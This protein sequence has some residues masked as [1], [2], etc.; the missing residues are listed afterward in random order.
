MSEEQSA[1]LITPQIAYLAVREALIA[2]AGEQA[3]VF[4]AVIAHGTDPGN[5]FTIKS[6][7]APG[8][9][10]VKIG[11]YWP[12]NVDI[13]RHGTTVLLVD[14]R[15]GRVHAVVEGAN[16]NAYRTA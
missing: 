4:P 8:F 5:I 9:A 13:P 16:V 11:S 7:S 6:G 2:A 10:G 14:Q 15:T 3:P 12:G 1:S